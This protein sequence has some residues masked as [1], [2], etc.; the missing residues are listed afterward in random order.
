MA[1]ANVY[2]MLHLHITHLTIIPSLSSEKPSD[3]SGGSGS[4]GHLMRAGG[5]CDVNSLT[6]LIPPVRPNDQTLADLEASQAPS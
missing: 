5:V 2:T 6:G 3:A 1:H 4:Q